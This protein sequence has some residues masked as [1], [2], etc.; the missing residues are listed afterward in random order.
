MEL[1]HQSLKIKIFATVGNFFDLYCIWIWI[2]QK[3]GRTRYNEYG[4]DPQHCN[5][6]GEVSLKYAILVRFDTDQDPGLCTTG[7]QNRIPIRIL[8]CYSAPFKMPTKSKFFLLRLFLFTG[9]LL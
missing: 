5:R 6:E 8:L 3:P 1:I 9:Y 4:T 7:L 2:H